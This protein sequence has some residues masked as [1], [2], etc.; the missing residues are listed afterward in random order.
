MLDTLERTHVQIHRLCELFLCNT[1][2][3][4]DAFQVPRE[5]G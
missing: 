3:L 1:S 5:N 2:L 4:A